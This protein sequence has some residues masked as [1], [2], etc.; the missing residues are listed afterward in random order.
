LNSKTAKCSGME[1]MMSISFSRSHLQSFTEPS[2]VHSVLQKAQVLCLSCCYFVS[3]EK[4]K[5][6]LC[7]F[8]LVAWT[9]LLYLT[10]SYICARQSCSLPV[11]SHFSLGIVCISD[12]IPV[13]KMGLFVKHWSSFGQ[14]FLH[15]TNL[16]RSL[17]ESNQG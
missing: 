12:D 13:C 10:L 7:I 11:P 15:F 1:L 6:A 3:S 9:G 17:L 14:S 4:C 8:H 5:L 16:C 2:V